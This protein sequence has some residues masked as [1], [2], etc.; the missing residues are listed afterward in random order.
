MQKRKTY[1]TRIKYLVRKG[2][3]PDLYRK[4]IHRS[5]I[6]KWSRET[7]DKY[8]GYELNDNLTELY[9]VLKK[10][11][12]D[13]RVLKTLKAFYRINKT[14]KDVIGTGKEYVVKLKEHKYK[15]VDAIQR[16]KKTITINRAIKLMGISRSTY[17]TWAMEAYFQCGQS[18]TKM[19]NNNY[20][21]QL[22]VNEIHKMHRLLSN[23]NYLHWPIISVAYYGMKKSLLKAHPN[24][25]YKYAR[26]MKIKRKR[27]RKIKI[28]YTE[29]VRANFPNENGMQI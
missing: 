26:L 10:V 11:S 12:E 20:P 23:A 19:C 16:A 7:D 24:T 13:D 28:K 27:Q 5:L 1:D 8:T 29:G 9:D 4:Q 2:L 22:T 21:Q 15:I 25:W 17:R 3:L 14:L 18:I 6:S